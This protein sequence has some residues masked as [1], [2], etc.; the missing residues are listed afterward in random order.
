MAIF[1]CKISWQNS[2]KFHI[3]PV[4]AGY[5]FFIA[6]TNLKLSL[7][8]KFIELAKSKLD[9][10]IPSDELVVRKTGK[11]SAPARLIFTNIWSR[12]M[13]YERKTKLRGTETFLSENLAPDDAILCFMR[14]K[15]YERRGKSRRHGPTPYGLCWEIFQSAIEFLIFGRSSKK[16]IAY[17]SP[18]LWYRTSHT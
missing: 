11:E 9:V 4:V 17:I 2:Q 15:N 14:H 13:C 8:K 7:A 16:L 6:S 3:L 5:C 1:S 12:N 10:E 18:W